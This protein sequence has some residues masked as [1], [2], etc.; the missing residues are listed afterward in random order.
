MED[1]NYFDRHPEQLFILKSAILMLA[2]ILGRKA[3]GGAVFWW[4]LSSMYLSYII[5]EATTSGSSLAKTIWSSINI[6]SVP[7]SA[8]K[9]RVKS[10][11]WVTTALI[12]I[13]VCVFLFFQTEDN[14]QFIKDNLTWMPRDPTW[15]NF[16]SSCI[17]AMFL[18][19]D[20]EHLFFNMIYLWIFGAVIERRIGHQLFTQLYFY[21]GII[22]H[23]VAMAI[24]LMFSDRPL[25][26][27][28]A[29]GAISGI[30]GI[31]M[32]RCYFRDVVFPIPLLGFLPVGLNVKM[33]A[34][35]ALGFY[36]AADLSGGINMISGAIER[37]NYWAHIG[38][39][40]AGIWLAY[41]FKF[42]R[43]A[44]EERYR[45]MGVSVIQDG[46]IRSTAS[47]KIGGFN[48]AEKA[49]RK[50]LE[51][52]P[53]NIESLTHLA[54]IKSHFGKTEEGCALYQKAILI[55]LKHS[56]QDALALFLEFFSKYRVLLPPNDQY[57]MSALIYRSG[58]LDLAART[59]EMLAEQTD[60]PAQLKPKALFQAAKILDKMDLPEAAAHLRN[61][62]ISEFA[63]SEEAA[64]T[65]AAVR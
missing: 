43:E 14:I 40:V 21:C 25:H 4:L 8:E 45:E 58:N 31:Y 18:H 23:I 51:I 65:T 28:G 53:E 42:Q 33:N 19:A 30:M 5:L 9:D 52:A 64:Y 1:R 27:L 34:F 16:Y 49:L 7:K 24:F 63:E 10:F 17:T 56:P 47:E 38:G 3:L 57:R 39:T 48:G 32:V 35:I 26:S 15:L 36:F 20:F 11:P 54:R 62:L 44:V 12:S 59:L 55:L 13:N 29:S 22:S 41:R 46:V 60:T 50:S 2:I 61:I 6:L 37:T